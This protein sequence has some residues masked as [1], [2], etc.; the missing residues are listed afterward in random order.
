LLLETIENTILTENDLASSAYIPRKKLVLFRAG[1]EAPLS[2]LNTEMQNLVKEVYRSAP[3]FCTFSTFG[4]FFSSDKL[5]PNSIP[6][7]LANCPYYAIM[8]ASLGFKIDSKIDALFL[9]QKSLSATLFD[10]FGSEAVDSLL[11]ALDEKLKELASNFDL[12]MSTR[13]SPGYGDLNLT[14][15]P[16]LLV[17]LKNK[18]DAFINGNQDDEVMH[19]AEKE[20]LIKLKNNTDLI[21]CN[22]NTGIF[23]PRKTV[24]AIA[25]LR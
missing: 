19:R 11:D 7:P 14:E 1:F 15:N 18:I 3:D 20:K 21:S 25:A 2:D 6:I 8:I 12:S 4:S 24:L 13:F 23:T 10:A 16:K 17:L 5:S 9:E 22:T